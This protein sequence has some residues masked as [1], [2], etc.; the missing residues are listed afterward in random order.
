MKKEI[1]IGILALLSVLQAQSQDVRGASSDV[2][3]A[4]SN[5]II[6][7]CA[8][9]IAAMLSILV[10]RNRQWRIFKFIIFPFIAFSLTVGITYLIDASILLSVNE[11]I[12]QWSR[13]VAAIV[14]LA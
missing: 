14:A 3:L 7:S 13:P 6:G 1:L 11:K 2:T 8:I 9:V 12:S 4:A 10:I 5:F